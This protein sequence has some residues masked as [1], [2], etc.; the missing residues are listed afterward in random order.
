MSEVVEGEVMEEATGGELALRRSQ[1]GGLPRI[2]FQMDEIVE[3]MKELDRFKSSVMRDG[4]DYGTIPGVPK[5]SLFKPG[6]ERLM[7]AFGFGSTVELI[8]FTEDWEGPL[9][10]YTYRAGVGPMMDGVLAPIA[11]CEGSA[12]NREIKYRYRAL[13]D[14]KAT[15]EQK[16]TA[17]KSEERTAKNGKSYMM[18]TVE[19]ENPADLI[20]TLQKMA[21]KRA[22]VGAVLLATG[23]SDFFTQDVEDS[24]PDLP[25]DDKP[26]KP[27]PIRT[28]M[29]DPDEPGEV[30]MPWGKKHK[31]QTL[32][33]ILDEDPQYLKWLKKALAEKEESGELPDDQIAL[34]SA[35]DLIVESM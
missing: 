6:A 20:N 15:D 28:P 4:V 2:R 5:P 3:A 35:V 9:F 17:V 27:K 32:N 22:I 21:Q 7:H 30:V 12:N 16:A 33:E 14:F 25:K 24:P 13:P 10:S 19:N 26:T 8:R 31:D 11:W 34:K 18:L 1:A 29:T 23:T